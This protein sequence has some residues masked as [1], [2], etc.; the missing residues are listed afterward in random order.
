MS[1]NRFALCGE[2]CPQVCVDAGDGL[3]DRDGTKAGEEMLDECAAARTTAAGRTMNA[4]EQLA[5]RDHADR[6]VFLTEQGL[7]G[8]GAD[9][10][11]QLD[12]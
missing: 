2:L 11:F 7:D 4:V 9:A 3:G 12:Q 8:R 10:T 6:P 5:D 1:A